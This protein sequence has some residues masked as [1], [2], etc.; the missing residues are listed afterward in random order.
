[1]TY[2]SVLTLTQERDKIN[3]VK[4]QLKL[5]FWNVQFRLY[6]KEPGVNLI[7][8]TNGQCRILESLTLQLLPAT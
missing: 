4:S 5:M 8:V 3:M 6:S 7:K 2:D 1:M